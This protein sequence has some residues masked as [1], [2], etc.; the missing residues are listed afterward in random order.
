MSVMS[1]DLSGVD[2]RVRKYASVYVCMCACVCMYAYVRVHVCVHACECVCACACAYVS[3]Y[4][5]VCVCVHT[6]MCTCVC[7]CAYVCT[8]V[9]MVHGACSCVTECLLPRRCCL[10]ER[11]CRVSCSA[12][13]C[14]RCLCSRES[15]SSRL[16]CCASPMPLCRDTAPLNTGSSLAY[17]LLL[18]HNNRYTHP[19]DIYTISG[20]Y[21]EL[22]A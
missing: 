12:L 13:S 2:V 1:V 22:L 20:S 19:P 7:A 5:C 18:T 6:C 21:V 11:L 14:V 17:V 8:C 16:A 9:C 15:R 3:A 10:G 4:T